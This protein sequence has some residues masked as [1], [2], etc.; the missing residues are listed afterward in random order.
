[1]MDQA[2]ACSRFPSNSGE[3]LELR[4]ARF[5]GPLRVAAS[6]ANFAQGRP[7][8]SCPLDDTRA[9]HRGGYSSTL[10]SDF[11]FDQSTAARTKAIISG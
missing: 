7:G 4:L 9:V 11:F 6:P 3:Q 8:K 2:R 1:M 10:S 5:Q